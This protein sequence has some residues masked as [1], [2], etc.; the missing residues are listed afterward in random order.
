M[1]KVLAG[2][3]VLTIFTAA[4]VDA[5]ES[6]WEKFEKKT[7]KIMEKFE[8]H[9]KKIRKNDDLSDEMKSLLIRQAKETRDLRLKHL[10]EKTDLKRK[11]KQ[12]TAVLRAPQANQQDSAQNNDWY[13]EEEEVEIVTVPADSAQPPQSKRPKNPNRQK[14]P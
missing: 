12:E 11:Q 14:T 1:K 6:C 8:K 3:L 4:P 5:K 10:K 2:F 7:E 13:V 9:L